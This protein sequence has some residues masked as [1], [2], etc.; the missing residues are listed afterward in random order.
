M[1]FVRDLPGK[2]ENAWATPM[3][4]GGVWVQLEWKQP[5]TISHVQITFD[6][7]FQ[8]VLT[9][10]HQD[11]FNAKMIRAPQPETVRDYE[12]VYRDRRDGQTNV[13]GESFGKPSAAEPPLFRANRGQGAASAGHGD[14]WLEGCKRLRD[15]LLCVRRA[16]EVTEP[17]AWR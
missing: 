13:L 8:R 10:T 12:L 9:L 7:G 17:P 1:G 14:E 4:E 3:R 5:R 2:T 16:G 6:T 11:D 15:S